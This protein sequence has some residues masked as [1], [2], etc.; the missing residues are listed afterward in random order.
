MSDCSIK[1]C[2]SG[3][4]KVYCPNRFTFDEM[5]S[6]KMALHLAPGCLEDFMDSVDSTNGYNSLDNGGK[7]MYDQGKSTIN[8]FEELEKK[9]NSL[10]SGVL[11]VDV[12]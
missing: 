2:E 7:V 5:C 6:L 4:N 10:L 11:G 9:V 3:G 1:E 8:K 12:K